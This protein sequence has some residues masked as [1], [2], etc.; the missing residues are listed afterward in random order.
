VES[1]GNAL[2]GYSNSHWERLYYQTSDRHLHVLTLSANAS[3]WV[4]EDLTIF[5]PGTLA[6]AGSPI[7]SLTDSSGEHLF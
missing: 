5:M 6:M 7:T 4:D 3:A 1:V 2:T